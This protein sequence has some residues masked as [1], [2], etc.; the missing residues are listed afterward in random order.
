MSDFWRILAISA[1][2]S[3]LAWRSRAVSQ[4]HSIAELRPLESYSNLQKA[5]ADYRTIEAEALSV[6]TDSGGGGPVN[7]EDILNVPNKF[8]PEEH[9][10]T[11]ALDGSDPIYP[12]TIGA[13]PTGVNIPW[14]EVEAPSSFTP[15]S[16]ALT[17]AEGGIDAITPESINACELTGGLIPINRLP[18]LAITDRFL[19]VS[20]VEMIALAAQLGDI[21][22][23][24]DQGRYYQKVNTYGLITDWVAWLDPP[25][26]SVNGLNGDVVLTPAIIGS[27]PNARVINAGTGLTGGGD[28]SAD[29]TLS[30]SNTAVTAGTYG[31]ST[32]TTSL[33]IDSQGRIT[34]ANNNT[35]SAPWSGITDNPFSAPITYGSVAVTG[36]LGAYVGI[37]FAS[38]AEP[39]TTFM[40]RASDGLSGLWTPAGWKW[41]WDQNG[42]LA[43]G[44]VPYARTTGCASATEAALAYTYGAGWSTYSATFAPSYSRSDKIVVL[45]G[46]VTRTTTTGILIATLPVG[47]RPVSRRAFGVQSSQGYTRVDVDVTGQILLQ[48]PNPAAA[49]VWVSL[50]GISFV[51]V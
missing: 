21:C 36:V 11:H 49:I 48:S 39:R 40:V 9:A 26:L 44:T 31:S 33:T 20:D 23:R 35:I 18:P 19:A 3:A 43:I 7:W 38:C 25:V 51:V 8:T 17:H 6:L 32:Q 50:D 24:S 34:L 30:L 45:A 13:R 46:L 2:G 28:L 5:T 37:Q 14:G 42:T 27:P 16:H 22:Y 12:L 4:G 1:Y 41:Y 29:I 47:Y 15:S 10:Y